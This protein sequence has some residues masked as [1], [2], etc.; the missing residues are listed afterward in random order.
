MTAVEDLLRELAPQVL[1]V[2]G[3]RYGDF[4]AA[5]DA[6]Q[7][8]LI[9]AA[10]HWAELPDNPRAWLIQTGSRK[11]LDHLRGES[12]R[13]RREELAAR[14]TAGVPAAEQDDTLTVLLLSCHPALSPA[15][16]VV[17]MRESVSRRD[18]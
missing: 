15:A 11:L 10:E 13:R 2:L 4:D 12:A 5:E 1:A 18:S 9:A 8:A 17:A 16:A 7:E 14:L 6:T 3:R